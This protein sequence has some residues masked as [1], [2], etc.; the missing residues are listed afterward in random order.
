VAPYNRCVIR[1]RHPAD[2][3][4]TFNMPSLCGLARGALL[5]ARGRAAGDLPAD[6]ANRRRGGSGQPDR[7]PGRAHNTFQPPGAAVDGSSTGT[8]VPSMWALLGQPMIRRSQDMQ[9]IT[10]VGLDI[11]KSVFQVHGVDTDGNV[12]VRVSSSDDMFWRSLR[13]CH[14]AWLASRPAHRRIIGRVNVRRSVRRSV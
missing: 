10:T 12:V 8:R 13:S 6:P 3:R 9:T 7:C 11:A 2:A 4:P 5:A 14:R 1:D